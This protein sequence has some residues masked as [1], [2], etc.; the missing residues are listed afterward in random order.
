[1]SFG[2]GTEADLQRAW[3]VVPRQSGWEFC[4]AVILRWAD[5]SR[6]VATGLHPPVSGKLPEV[7]PAAPGTTAFALD[8]SRARART[9]REAVAVVR[10]V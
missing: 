2:G 6:I 4:G 8:A 9:T 3:I 7:V 10:A 1:M 5:R